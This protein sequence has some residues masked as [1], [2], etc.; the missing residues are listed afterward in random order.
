M[1]ALQ[2]RLLTSEFKKLRCLGMRCLHKQRVATPI[3]SQ[4]LLAI[5]KLLTPGALMLQL[6]MTTSKRRE[7]LKRGLCVQLEKFK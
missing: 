6:L 1:S 2:D 5:P 4:A 7:K 3:L